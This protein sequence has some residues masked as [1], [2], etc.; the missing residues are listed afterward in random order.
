MY[1]IL[2]VSDNTDSLFGAFSNLFEF[3]KNAF[4]SFEIK[5]AIDILL[6][7]V[8]FTFCFNFLK[9]KKAGTLIL[10]IVICMAVYILSVWFELSGIKF[11]LSGLFQIGVLALVII[12]HPELRELL[13][14]VGSGSIKGI[15]NLSQESRNKQK[16]YVTIQ[17]ICKAVH[18]LSVE[19]TGALIVISRNTSLDEVLHSGTTINAD[20]SD[21][22]LRNLFYN[23]APLHDGAVVIEGDRIAAASCILPLPKRTVVD[24]DLGTRHRAAIGLSEISDAIIIVV[25]EETGIVSVAVECELVRGFN[26]D[27]LRNFLVKEL[28]KEG[29]EDHKNRNFGVTK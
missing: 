16:Q 3:A 10:G 12:F 26:S 9:Q 27:S 8:I 5:D 25:S 2:S 13:E 11:I 14:R 24:G 1:N 20:V 17:N 28:L 21:S 4:L 23:R 7:T 6:L 29:N 22:L 19:K 15:R 18:V